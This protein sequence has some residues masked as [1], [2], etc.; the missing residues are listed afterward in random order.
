MPDEIVEPLGHCTCIPLAN[1]FIL[2]IRLDGWSLL[3]SNMFAKADRL[4]NMGWKPVESDKTSLMESL[5]A[6]IDAAL[7]DDKPYVHIS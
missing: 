2:I 1:R 7:E 3:G 6:M 4:V 5:P